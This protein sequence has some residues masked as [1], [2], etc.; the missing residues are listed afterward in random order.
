MDALETAEDERVDSRLDGTLL[1]PIKATMKDIE[2]QELTISS[3]IDI[4]IDTHLQ[5]RG[6]RACPFA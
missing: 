4:R 5:R 6:Q 2:I 3:V 1:R